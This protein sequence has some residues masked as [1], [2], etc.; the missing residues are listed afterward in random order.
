MAFAKKKVYTSA[1]GTAEPYAY[2]AKP[3]FGQGSFKN[4]RGVYKVQLTIPN[5]KCQS[6]ID[7]IVKCHEENYAARVEEYEANPPAVQRGK[8]PLQPYEGDMP[9]FDNGDGTTTFTFK[10]YG[11]FTDKKTGE[12]KPINLVV[13]D[14][15]GKKIHDVPMVAGGSKLKVK[16]S[17][18]PYGWSKVAGASVK[19]QLEGVM[20]V[21]LATFGGAE[22]DWG[23]DIVEGG[24]EAS[25]STRRP[26]REDVAE[27]GWTPEEDVEEDDSDGDF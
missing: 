26:A 24:Y 10:C 17:M 5:A 16:F 21:E 23:D 25:E 9:F 3:D 11:S 6:M 15:K 8:K 13:V 7:A 18:I 19:L 4:E 1:L 22:D 14:S 27:G 12:N 2:I 20:I